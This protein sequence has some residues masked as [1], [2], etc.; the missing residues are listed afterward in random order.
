MILVP[1]EILPSRIHGSGVFAMA[2]IPKGAEV[3]RGVDD[4]YWM[5]E[6]SWCALPEQVRSM[7][8]PF[9]WVDDEG[10]YCGSSGPEQFMNHSEEPNLV[11]CPE[12]DEVRASRDIAAGEELTQD[13][14]TFDR[15]FEGYPAPS[16]PRRVTR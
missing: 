9:V 15:S 10:N 4:F 13:Y 7:L 5:D 3:V 14:A 11:W 6:P 16:R 12:T 8:E 2:P 1:H